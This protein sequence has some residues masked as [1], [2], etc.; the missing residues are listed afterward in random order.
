MPTNPPFRD[1]MPTLED[2]KVQIR[3]YK[4]QPLSTPLLDQ[5]FSDLIDNAQWDRLWR[6]DCN[7]ITSTANRYLHQCAVHFG[8]LIRE[9]QERIRVRDEAVRKGESNLETWREQS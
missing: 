3:Q 5:L 8:Q 1:D 2:L 4:D 6:Y 7:K 9:L